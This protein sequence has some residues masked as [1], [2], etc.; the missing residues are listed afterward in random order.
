MNLIDVLL[1]EHGVLYALF[2]QAEGSISEAETLAEVR[3]AA[4][5]LTATLISHAKI[6][7]EILFPAL[8]THLGP[9]GPLAVMR[10]EHEEIERTLWDVMKVDEKPK[11]VSK[12]LQA[13]LVAREHFA[14]EEQVLF[15]IARQVLGEAALSEMGDR[16]AAAR[17]VAVG[18]VEA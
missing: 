13:L 16:W 12:V 7:D 9:M 15:G 17:H 11:A 8:E 4:G 14:K 2:D 1:G 10:A 5:V 18:A 6:E 3:A